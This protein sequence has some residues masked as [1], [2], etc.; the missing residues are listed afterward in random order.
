MGRSCLVVV[1][2]GVIHPRHAVVHHQ[3]AVVE[4]SAD[5]KGPLLAIDA[6][7]KY[8]QAVGKRAVT[9]GNWYATKRVIDHFMSV[10]N[11]QRIR[12]GLAVHHYSRHAVITHHVLGSV[13]VIPS[14]HVRTTHDGGCV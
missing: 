6:P 5:M 8:H 14:Q 12:A 9:H 2:V 4:Q 3:V 7:I 13:L 1:R 11:S 10:E